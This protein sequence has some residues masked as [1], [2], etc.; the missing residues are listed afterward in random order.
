M[1]DISDGLAQDL[2]H[3]LKASKAGAVLDL[4]K[5]PVSRDAKRMSRG[6]QEK[7]LERAL[8]DG[9]DFELLF[10]IPPRQV[11]M[12]EKI[13]KRAFPKVPLNW[14]GKIE[15]KTSQISWRREGR[16]V[17]A[18]KLDRKGFSHF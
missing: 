2:S 9:E 4:D 1:I 17:A 18:P 16:K 15:G 5:I 7:A 14:I 10:T 12:L 3:I 6:D 11:K 8:T 13:W